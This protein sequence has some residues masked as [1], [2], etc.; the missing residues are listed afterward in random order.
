MT[1]VRSLSVA[2]GFV[3]LLAFLAGCSES[4]GAQSL[5]AGSSGPSHDVSADQQDALADGIVTHDE[6][7]AGYRRFVACLAQSGFVVS[8]S[9]LRYGV[10]DY[11]V[12]S[13]AIAAGEDRRCYGLEFEALDVQWQLAHEESS[14]TSELI[15]SCLTKRGIVPA[16]SVDELHTQ[17]DAAGLSLEQC[18]QGQ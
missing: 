8:D 14:A 7:E 13:D 4:P 2:G 16:R 18:V 1:P 12:P 3:L 5:S 11:G 6:Y 15:A 9:G 10:H 17:L